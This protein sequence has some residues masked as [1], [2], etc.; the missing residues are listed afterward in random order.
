MNRKA[1]EGDSEQIMSTIIYITLAVIFLL[2]MMAY[3]ELQKNG[4]SNWEDFYAKEIANIVNLVQPNDQIILDVQPAT[5]IAE[6]TK[7]QMRK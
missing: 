7:S 6:Q 1:E 2:G 5:Q 4:A 3:I